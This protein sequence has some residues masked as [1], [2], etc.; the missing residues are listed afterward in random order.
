MVRLVDYEARRRAVLGAAIERY[1]KH[2]QPVSSEDIAKQFRLSSATIRNI[3]ADLE[4]E[5][6]LM[7][8]YTSGGRIPTKKGYRYYVDVLVSQAELLEEEKEHIVG[9]FK[10]EI[11]RLEDILD[12]TAGAISRITH[13]AGIASFLEWHDRFFYKGLNLILNQP[14]FQEVERI[15][16]LVQMIEERQQLLKIINRDFKDDKI[17]I[18]VGEELECPGMDSCALV[19]SSYKRKNQPSGKIAVL[20]PMRMEY[21]HIIP[22]LEYISGVLTEVMDRT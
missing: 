8:P 12:Q 1:I 13:Y 18:Y 14:E 16:L 2:A 3:F 17:K 10:Q 9:E 22:T 4:E 5:G 6:Y 19:V 11:G 20:G 7:H 21:E 15:R